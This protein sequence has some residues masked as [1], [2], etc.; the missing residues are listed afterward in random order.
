MKKLWLDIETRSR[1]DLIKR[2]TYNYGDDRSTEV[3][4]IA[5]AFDN[6]P[7]R[8]WFKGQ[9]MPDAL[10]AAFSKRYGDLRLYA[11]NA[12]FERRVLG[13]SFP[14]LRDP[15]IWNCTMA[16]AR[17]CALP[18]S[19]EDA[20]RMLGTKRKNP[21]GKELIRLLSIPQ[22][23]GQFIEDAKLMEEFAAY[24]ADDVTA[25]RSLANALPRFPDEALA[26]YHA[27]EIV[28]DKGMVID[29]EL[30]EAALRYAD[31]SEAEAIERIKLLTDGKVHTPRGPRCTQWI[32]DHIP[33]AFQH[34]MLPSRLKAPADVLHAG[35]LSDHG[36]GI[37]GL[38]DTERENRLCLDA[39]VRGNLFIAI[40]HFP[41]AFDAQC[42]EALEAV[43]DAARSSVAKFGR[44]L[45]MVNRDGRLRGAFVMNGAAQ[46]GR[47]SSRGAQLHN[48]PREVAEEP[49]VTREAIVKHRL[50]GNVLKTL[51]SMLRPAIRPARGRIVQAD[52]NA[53]EARALPWLANEGVDEYLAMWGNP[54][55]DPYSEQAKLCGLTQRQ[56][57]KAIVLSLGYGGGV[58][59][60]TRTSRSYGAPVEHPQ[61][62]VANWRQ[63][64]PWAK[65]W[66]QAL[67]F[68]AHAALRQKDAKWYV[69]GRVAF[70]H[71]GGALML[72]L[73]SGRD[74]FYPLPAFAQEGQSDV[75]TYAKAA[76][77]PKAAATAW[78][79]AKIW[80][81]V[82]AENAT[83][84]CCADLLRAA[85]VRCV[86]EGLPLVGHVHDELV[87]EVTG[88]REGVEVA[89]AL[90]RVMLDPPGWAEGLPL[91]VETN[92]RRCFAK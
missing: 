89:Q 58:N 54:T 39:E 46:T 62:V 16:H 70:T 75:I 13:A 55:R 9:R 37:R 66:W 32:F 29:T 77:K 47:Y 24:C 84:A 87:A 44:M 18:G 72:R 90:K 34:I 71:T 42:V 17:A 12:T 76:W 45:E 14:A 64:N 36:C 61:S 51:K 68:A 30:C 7:V 50:D 5:Y 57:G 59:A 88:E 63:A 85:I 80:H 26:L 11:H 1:C 60:L 69:A 4:I 74:L 43:E 53:V 21:R 91:A 22:A 38:P 78:P 65:R 2:G 31:E 10:L 49:H 92:V 25:M 67:A 33:E 40:E 79:R 52:W 48:F 23:D 56:H 3:L 27:S 41:D 6:D 86:S 82:L 8:L 73:P 20:A 35:L 81:G 15:R 83:Q 28:N 19:L